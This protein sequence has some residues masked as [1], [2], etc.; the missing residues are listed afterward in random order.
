MDEGGGEGRWFVFC[1]FRC[2]YIVEVC[3]LELSVVTEKVVGG[4]QMAMVGSDYVTGLGIAPSLLLS[5]A[6][7]VPRSI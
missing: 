3:S 4:L 5:T 2:S 7:V 1:H 6:F